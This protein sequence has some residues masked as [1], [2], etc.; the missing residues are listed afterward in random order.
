MS[1]NPARLVGLKDRGRIVPGFRGDL[2]II[3]TEGSWIV[4]P[5]NL[6]TKGKNSPFAGRSLYGKILMTIQ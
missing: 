5:A 3:D 4:D 2:V 1:A 6:K